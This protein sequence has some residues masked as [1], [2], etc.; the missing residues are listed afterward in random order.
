[1]YVS[2][3]NLIHETNSGVQMVRG[4]TL[5]EE[6]AEAS[7]TVAASLKNNKRKN[8]KRKKTKKKAKLA[9]VRWRWT[10][11]PC[12]NNPTYVGAY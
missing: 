1:M 10:H 3:T 7:S 12:A 4:F 6:P 8:N 5:D 2:H 9:E 11:H